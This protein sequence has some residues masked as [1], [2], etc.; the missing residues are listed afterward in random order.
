MYLEGRVALVTGASR[1][2][3]APIAA[4]L[5]RE[6][7]DVAVGYESDR[8]AVSRITSRAERAGRR[9]VAV[10]GDLRNPAAV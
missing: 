5:A 8:D 6:G 10:G 3:G 1:D 9:A 7:A 4:G 2:I